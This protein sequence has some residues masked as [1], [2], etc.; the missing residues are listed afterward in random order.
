VFKFHSIDQLISTPEKVYW[1]QTGWTFFG[2]PI[3]LVFFFFFWLYVCN[4]I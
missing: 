1:I 2:F 3:C 4:N